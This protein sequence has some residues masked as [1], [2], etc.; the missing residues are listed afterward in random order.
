MKTINVRGVL[1]GTGRTKIIC[2]VV[3]PTIEAALASVEQA[4]RL[5]VDA[6]E[7]R[8]DWSA[9]AHNM[10]KLMDDLRLMRAALGDLPLLYTFRS[11]PEGGQS[12]LTKNEY[13]A[14]VR[15]AI[16]T[17]CV[18]MIDIEHNIGDAV[19]EELT[20]YARAAGVISVLSV[21]NFKETPGAEWICD[22][23]GHARRLGADI[24]KCAVMAHSMDDLITLLAAT[25]RMTRGADDTPVLTVAMGRD[26]VLSRIAGEFFGS[27][28]TFCTAGASSAPG[29]IDCERAYAAIQALHECISE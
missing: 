2:P 5:H 9:N 10:E 24:P 17:G 18:D 20:A 27:C 23:I 1:L 29:Q 13:T 16:S 25:G 7:Y 15:A 12:E 22:Y 19:A 8:A 11:V 3:D 28:M 6:I 4:K 14:L 26:G 21:H